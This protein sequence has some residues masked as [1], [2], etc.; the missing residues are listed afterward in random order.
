[1]GDLRVVLLLSKFEL[2][3][4]NWL[5]P[6]FH[7]P[8]LHDLYFYRNSKLRPLLI[9]NRSLHVLSCSKNI[10]HGERYLICLKVTIV[11]CSKS[12]F[13]LC[14]FLL[15][16]RCFQNKVLC[17]L[18]HLYLCVSK[19]LWHRLTAGFYENLSCEKLNPVVDGIGRRVYL[20]DILKEFRLNGFLKFSRK[21]ETSVQESEKK[22]TW[23]LRIIF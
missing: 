13:L 20:F 10:R 23:N 3:D 8:V 5:H 22:I 7:N 16:M 6:S 1:M 2:A 9:G 17:V 21:C 4:C 12:N 15:F 19:K 14:Q 11:A 18:G